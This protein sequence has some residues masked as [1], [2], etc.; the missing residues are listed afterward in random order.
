[1]TV[2]EDVSSI[3][4]LGAAYTAYARDTI[5]LTWED[6]R[7]G[8]G[9][10]RSDGGIA[11]AIS[12]PAGTVLK[13]DDCFVL[14]AEKTIV[15]VHEAK[16]PVYVMRP[17]TP[18]DWALFAYHVGNRHQPVMIGEN[19]LIFLESPAVRSLLDQLRAEYTVDTR[20]FTAAL[21]GYAH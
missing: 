14:P 19:E 20:P 3:A 1:M 16:E 10:R 8:H 21:V 17:K 6:R 7:R 11:F 9:R 5:T 4:A 12:L 18:Q 15:V 2:V 13:S